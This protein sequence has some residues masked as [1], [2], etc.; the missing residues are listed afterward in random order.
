MG[1]SKFD[2][3]E[4]ADCWKLKLSCF[5]VVRVDRNRVSDDSTCSKF[6]PEIEKFSSYAIGANLVQCMLT[7]YLLS[8]NERR[9]RF[10]EL[11]LIWST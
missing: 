10:D 8:D 9:S 7:F 4:E 2:A 3:L 5:R 1:L 11:V 6:T